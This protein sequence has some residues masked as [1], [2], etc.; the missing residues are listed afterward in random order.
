MAQERKGSTGKTG[1]ELRQTAL[2]HLWVQSQQWNDLA[3]VGGPIIIEEGEGVKLKDV[4]GNWYYDGSAGA[5]LVNIGHGRQ[6]LA[7]AAQK[8]MASVSYASIFSFATVPVIELAEKVASLTPGDLN[9]VAF[10]SGGSEAV[11]T[12]LKMAYQ[13]HVNLGEPQRTKFIA[14]PGF[15]S[16]GQSGGSQR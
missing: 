1:D 11:E 15:L 13:Y 16:W 10:T 6:E 3:A 7:E 4:Q 14:R 2:D 8:Q 12:A 9:H 5:A